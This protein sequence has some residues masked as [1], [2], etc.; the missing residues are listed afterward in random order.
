[1]TDKK[2][3]RWVKVRV[4]EDEYKM[5]KHLQSIKGFKFSEKIR[6]CIKE[7]YEKNPPEL[8]PT[9]FEKLVAETLGPVLLD[10]AKS[11]SQVDL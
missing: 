11:L 10:W 3:T 6:E 5:A 2:R 9:E 1:M 7:L 4:N 8:P